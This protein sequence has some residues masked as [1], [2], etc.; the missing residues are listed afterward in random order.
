MPSPIELPPELGQFPA[1]LYVFDLA[2]PLQKFPLESEV[3]T[4]YKLD[5]TADAVAVPEP[6]SSV[7]LAVGLASMGARRWRQRKA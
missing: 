7:L 3:T 6:T 1:G 2:T 4:F 5:L